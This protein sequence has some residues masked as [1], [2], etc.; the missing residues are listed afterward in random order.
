MKAQLGAGR[1]AGLKMF[2]D[3]KIR[4][5]VGCCGNGI[6]HPELSDR[7]ESGDDQGEGLGEKFCCNDLSGN[8][9]DGNDEAEASSRRSGATGIGKFRICGKISDLPR[10]SSACATVDSVDLFKS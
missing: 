8:G 2:G 10:L 5:G 1:L 7:I 3:G 9:C 6:E 4:T